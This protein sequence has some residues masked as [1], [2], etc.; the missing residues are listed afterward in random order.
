MHANRLRCAQERA[1]VVDILNRIPDEQE[2][3]LIFVTSIGQNLIQIDILT[4]FD[5]CQATPVYSSLAQLIEPL[6]WPN[7]GRDMPAFSL[8]QDSSDRR[9][10][11]LPLCQQN[12]LDPA[13]R[14]QCL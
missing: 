10:S 5:A 2:R 4:R 7:V 8:L 3:G 13:R 11:A 14:M 6:A 9:T 1:K 12:A